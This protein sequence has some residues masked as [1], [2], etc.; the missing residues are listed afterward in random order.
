V[1][2]C[3]LESIVLVEVTKANEEPVLMSKLIQIIRHAAILTLLPETVLKG[4]YTFNQ[5][6]NK[7]ENKYERFSKHLLVVSNK[8]P[9][10]GLGHFNKCYKSL[11]KANP[12]L[13][14][15]L[16][17]SGFSLL[18]VE[19]LDNNCQLFMPY[20]KKRTDRGFLIQHA[21]LLSEHTENF[22]E[23]K[24]G[25]IAIAKALNDE[26]AVNEAFRLKTTA[27]V[28]S[29]RQNVE[30][31]NTRVNDLDTK[32]TKIET[33]VDDIEMKVTALQIES[34]ESK[35]LLL[36]IFDMVVSFKDQLSTLNSPQ[37]KK[38]SSTDTQ[39]ALVQV[40]NI[41]Q[42]PPEDKSPEI[43]STNLGTPD[44]TDTQSK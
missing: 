19:G 42:S 34:A 26:Q 10:I 21:S 41:P 43:T 6:T 16:Q 40:S 23:L 11:M 14:D 37:P 15:Y 31:L 12:L 35:K 28:Q 39:T 7:K 27:D 36:S 2:S 24:A 44:S 20:L 32:T 38:D 8:D 3:P 13:K 30:D 17:N 5:L 9:C 18:K 29:L 33:K 4:A 1:I 25:L 22:L